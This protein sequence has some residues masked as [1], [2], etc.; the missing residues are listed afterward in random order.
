MAAARAVV[1]Q[2]AKAWPQRKVEKV[3][4]EKTEE[5]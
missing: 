1:M 2:E 4:R 5:T 3:V